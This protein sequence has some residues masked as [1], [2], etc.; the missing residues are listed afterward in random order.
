MYSIKY[1]FLGEGVFSQD[2]PELKHSRDLIRPTFSR[3]ELSDLDSF[4][5]HVA[6]F[7]EL[8][9]S[10][11]AQLAFCPPLQRIVRKIAPNPRNRF[12]G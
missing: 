10:D 2:G 6:R 5:F 3:P 9:P 8:I 11:E 12:K 1:P 4:V 7:L